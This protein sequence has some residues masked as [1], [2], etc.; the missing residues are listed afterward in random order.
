MTS[1][2][3]AEAIHFAYQNLKRDSIFWETDVP[4]YL[5]V[6]MSESMRVL[7]KM[8][9]GNIVERD[10]HQLVRDKEGQLV[11]KLGER[12]GEFFSVY[13]DDKGE[14]LIAKAVSGDQVA[15]N[16]L[17]RIAARFIESGCVMPMRLR[18]YIAETL[19]LQFKKAPQPRR[20][21]DPYANHLRDIDIARAVREV[22]KLGFNPTRNRATETE[23][24]CSIVAQALANLGIHR[25]VPAIEKIWNASRKRSLENSVS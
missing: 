8:P 13:D 18:A 25:S 22:V 2:K 14:R 7:T 12:T 3:I 10:G 20:G 9:W 15:H 23:S 17:G 11:P 4:G 21:Q 16:V 1:E 6:R 24:A 19:F 5:H